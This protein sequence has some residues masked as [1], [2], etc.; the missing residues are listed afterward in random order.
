[1]E[2]PLV[3]ILL[4]IAT[5]SPFLDETLNSLMSQDYEHV[6]YVIVINH[7]DSHILNQV[8]T[9]MI[10]SRLKIVTVD[11]ESNLSVR[12]NEGVQNCSGKYIARADA[13]DCYPTNRIS[14]QLAFLENSDPQVSLVSCQG[15][16]IDSKGVTFGRIR[17]P[18]STKNIE[19]ML[20]FKNCLIHPA[21]MMRLEAALDFSYDSNL[22][23]GEDYELWLRMG[24]KYRIANLDSVLIHYRVHGNNMSN[25]RLSFRSIAIVARRKWIYGQLKNFG[26]VRITVSIISWS[27]KNVFFGPQ[28]LIQIRRK[29]LTNSSN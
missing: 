20:M 21:V 26:R 7:G 3:S 29:F 4:P 9:L 25:R 11:Q 28:F 24:T 12:L 17:V 1:M 5:E 10:G 19:S 13:D 15:N 22:Y 18:T 14:A 16:L 23:S 2:K 8:R 27:L 6:E